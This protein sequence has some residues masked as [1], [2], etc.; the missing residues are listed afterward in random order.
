MLS[1]KE[2]ARRSEGG[3]CITVQGSSA[4][5]EKTSNGCKRYKRQQGEGL[6]ALRREGHVTSFILQPSFS[7]AARKLDLLPPLRPLPSVLAAMLPTMTSQLSRSVQQPLWTGV[8]ICKASTSKQGFATSSASRSQ[9]TPPTSST[10]SMQQTETQRIPATII[11]E[12]TPEQPASDGLR[13]APRT[14]SQLPDYKE[15]IQSGAKQYEYTPRGRGPFWIGETPYPLN[16][17][18]DPSPP[19]AQ[20]QKKALW[21]LHQSDPANTVRVLSGK[22]GISMERLR[23]ILRLQALESEWQSKVSFREWRCGLVEGRQEVKA[24]SRMM[25]HITI[26]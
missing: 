9:D 17:S 25:R 24:G 18:F 14:L 23:A 1:E 22:Y 12:A 4:L 13:R 2:T 8:R 10:S 3:L 15:W 21:K 11:D 20:S 16:P 7:F 6:A 19:I 5:T 26:D